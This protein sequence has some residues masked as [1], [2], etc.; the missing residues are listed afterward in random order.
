[1]TDVTDMARRGESASLYEARLEALFE[2]SHLST[3][4]SLKTITD[5]A[6]E[7]AIRL[8]HSKIGYLAFTNKDE[9]IISMYSWSRQAMKECGLADK[10]IDYVTADTGLWGE[11][12]RQRKA[13]ITND[14]Q[15]P[16]PLKKG[17]PEGHLKIIRNMN[18]PVFEKDHIVAVAGVGNKA[19]YQN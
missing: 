4:S 14:Y 12:V 7:E 17:Y 13:I 15:A 16:N 3:D 9:S 6:L 5:F 1:M 11:V 8:T 19:R 18:I 10:P 2:L